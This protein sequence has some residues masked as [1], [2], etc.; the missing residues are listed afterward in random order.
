MQRG[1]ESDGGKKKAGEHR[2]AQRVWGHGWSGAKEYG[3]QGEGQGGGHRI[4]MLRIVRQRTNLSCRC[5]PMHS[6]LAGRTPNLTVSMG[7]IC[8]VCL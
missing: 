3:Q 8:Y 7:L 5:L 2:C 4:R 6:S 1:G